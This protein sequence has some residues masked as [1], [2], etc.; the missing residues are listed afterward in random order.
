MLQQVLSRGTSL[1]ATLENCLVEISSDK[2]QPVVDA[3]QQ[4]QSFHNKPSRW[5]FVTLW[6]VLSTLALYLL[7]V[8][9]FT[10]L[11]WKSLF[12]RPLF[13]RA[14]K[15]CL[16]HQDQD[17]MAPIIA[18]LITFMRECYS[19]KEVESDVYCCALDSARWGNMSGVHLLIVLVLMYIHHHIIWLLHL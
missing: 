8:C 10:V 14:L 1:S 3:I 15:L 16:H 7:A 19:K 2:P 11:Y 4:M 13:R 6:L 12:L 17:K 18:K 9:V 5:A